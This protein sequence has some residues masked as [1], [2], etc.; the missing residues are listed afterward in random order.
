MVRDSTTLVTDKGNPGL[1]HSRRTVDR[2]P[3]PE[4]RELKIPDLTGPRGGSSK[5]EMIML[6]EMP[7]VDLNS[8]KLKTEI[9]RDKSAIEAGRKFTRT[10]PSPW[11]LKQNL[12]WGNGK[13]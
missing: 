1:S 5:G 11:E 2:N 3:R 6:R 10:Y 4:P 12:K 7:Y 13:N 8:K 9:D